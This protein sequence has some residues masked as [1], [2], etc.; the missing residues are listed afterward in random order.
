LERKYLLAGIGIAIIIIAVIG[1][2][3]AYQNYKTSQIQTLIKESA[4]HNNSCL[5]YSNQSIT[6]AQKKDY[7]NAIIY[8]K[9]AQDEANKA[10]DLDNQAMQYADGIY[11]DFLTNDIMRLKMDIKMDDYNIQ[12]Y[13]SNNIND[14][15]SLSAIINQYSDKAHDYRDKMDELMVA[16]PTMFSFLNS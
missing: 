6:Y 16:N 8:A 9:K 7:K 4:Q 11:K 5:N 13:K 3:Y 14:L 1:G 2:S 15:M 10:I 12:A